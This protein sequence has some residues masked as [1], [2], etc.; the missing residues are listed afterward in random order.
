MKSSVS[1]P[2]S[3]RKTVVWIGALALLTGVGAFAAT[4][5][6]V[7]TNQPQDQVVGELQSAIFKVA[8]SGI[9]LP[10]YQ[11]Y[12][13]DIAIPDATN[14]TYTLP[15]ALLSDDGALFKAIAR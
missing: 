12:K 1:I 4:T 3:L 9:P 13:N 5:P 7:I 2:S 6:V 15:V 11:W 10:L 8:A 14:K